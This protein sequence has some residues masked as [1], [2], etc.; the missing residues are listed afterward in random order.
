MRQGRRR[1]RGCGKGCPH[2]RGLCGSPEPQLFGVIEDLTAHAEALHQEKALLVRP[3]P[4]PCRWACQA[5]CLGCRCRREGQSF[6]NA[7]SYGG[8]Y[9]GF[10]ATRDQYVR[11][12]PG[13]LAGE[14]VDTEGRR[15][16]V[17]TLSTREQHIRR[18][19]GH[20]EHLHQRRIMRAGGDDSSLHQSGLRRLA[21]LNLHAHVCAATAR[22]HSRL[23]RTLHRADVQRIRAGNP[24]PAGDLIRQ[25]SAQHLIP[26]LTWGGFIRSVRT[27]SSCASPR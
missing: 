14:T 15:G 18:E 24:Q 23:S 9:L 27:S 1:W 8:P 4:S 25:L 11:Q 6:G 2:V 20:L 19:K 21:E 7:L 26:A 16:Y 22:R 17:L 5:S 3:S 10:F 12:M 13:R